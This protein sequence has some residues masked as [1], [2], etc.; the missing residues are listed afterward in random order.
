MSRSSVRMPVVLFA[1]L[2][3]LSG[4]Q[5]GQIRSGFPETEGQG[6]AV[7]E[8]NVDAAVPPVGQVAQELTRQ[9]C[10]SVSTT[11][12]EETG[13]T[14]PPARECPTC[15]RAFPSDAA[16][17]A[18]IRPGQLADSELV[19]L[20]F[21]GELATAFQELVRKSK[22]TLPFKDPH[23]MSAMCFACKLQPPALELS[24]SMEQMKTGAMVTRSPEEM[25]ASSSATQLMAKSTATQ[26]A[27]MVV[28]DRT[29]TGEPISTNEVTR[30]STNACES[31]TREPSPRDP[32]ENC[33][34][35]IFA[36]EAAPAEFQ[37]EVSVREAMAAAGRTFTM[38]DGMI[39]IGSQ[40]TNPVVAAQVG[41]RILVGTHDYVKRT[42]EEAKRTAEAGDTNVCPMKEEW[43]ALPESMFKAAGDPA[44][45]SKLTPTER[46]NWDQAFV[47]T[48]EFYRVVMAADEQPEKKLVA[49]AKGF[50]RT[51]SEPIFEMLLRVNFAEFKESALAKWLQTLRERLAGGESDKAQLVQQIDRTQMQQATGLSQAAPEKMLEQ[52]QQKTTDSI[53]MQQVPQ[54]Q[55][56]NQN[57]V[58]E[59]A[60][61][62]QLQQKVTESIQMQQMPQQTT[63]AIQ[64]QQLQQQAT[65]AIQMQ[66]IPQ[67]SV[68]TLQAVPSTQQG[69][70]TAGSTSNTTT[71]SS[72]ST[73]TQTIQTPTFEQA[74]PTRMQTVSPT[75]LNNLQRR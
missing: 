58:F 74:A 57:K 8:L 38:Q 45:M 19:K 62:E 42:I 67:S 37:L 14:P 71:S 24:R 39:V 69:L 61:I 63:D 30:P 56:L 46:A 4:C 3:I 54:Q 26:T 65:E 5:G 66:Q 73:T 55:Q 7:S 49:A 41:N 70:T 29:A 35:Y 15:M 10:E 44:L 21:G 6:A 47:A 31:G 36:V 11:T 27:S 17:V 20:A 59:A 43:L 1:V 50:V 64:M 13:R 60:P 51:G 32:L 16:M 23:E 28:G 34:D 53:Q 33:S 2:A 12:G 72:G 9:V 52:V 22:G 25:M 40:A 18:Q 75:R 68:T 48:P